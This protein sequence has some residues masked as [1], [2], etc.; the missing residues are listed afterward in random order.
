M[1]PSKLEIFQCKACLTITGA[2]QGTSKGDNTPANSLVGKTVPFLQEL[3]FLNFRLGKI[4]R[5]LQFAG[6]ILNSLRP[7]KS[8]FFQNAQDNLYQSSS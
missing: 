6:L 3:T 4:S 5:F 2:M 7:T 8:C 1:V